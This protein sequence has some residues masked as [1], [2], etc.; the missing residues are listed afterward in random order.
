MGYVVSHSVLC[1]EL[2][3]AI[4]CGLERFSQPF[5]QSFPHF[6]CKRTFTLSQEVRLG[7]RKVHNRRRFSVTKASVHECIEPVVQLFRED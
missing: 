2:K 5:P 6:L 7:G 3:T 1:K 4:F